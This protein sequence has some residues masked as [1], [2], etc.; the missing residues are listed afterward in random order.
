M[1]DLQVLAGVLHSEPVHVESTFWLLICLAFALERTDQWIWRLDCESA[2]AV[3]LY[4]WLNVSCLLL[5]FATS[6]SVASLPWV[7]WPSRFT[8]TSFT[9]VWSRHRQLRTT[10]LQNFVLS[11]EK[12]WKVNMNPSSM[13]FFL[14]REVSVLS[15]TQIWRTGL[16]M[17]CLGLYIEGRNIKRSWKGVGIT[18]VA[19]HF[20]SDCIVKRWPTCLRLISTWKFLANSRSTS[21]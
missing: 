21:R 19:W 3:P 18:P 16:K 8:I 5:I 7:W 10:H 12:A 2:T 9:S 17:C 4:P 15:M 6:T 14:P 1:R 13:S 11:A 20:T